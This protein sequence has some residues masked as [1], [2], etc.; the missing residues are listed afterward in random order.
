MDYQ[1]R[2][3]MC[4]LVCKASVYVCSTPTP[5][6]GSGG[7]LPSGEQSI[8]ILAAHAEDWPVEEERDGCQCRV[9]VLELVY[10]QFR[11]SFYVVLEVRV[12]NACLDLQLS[13]KNIRN[14]NV[15][16]IESMFFD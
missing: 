12:T 8:E 9:S 11:K 10:A 3:R 16:A 4:S 1:P 15:G 5:A 7:K 6:R 2:T 14:P 13:T